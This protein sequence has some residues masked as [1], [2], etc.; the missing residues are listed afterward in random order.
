MNGDGSIETNG[1]DRVTQTVQDVFADP[2]NGNVQRTRTFVWYT[3]S[4]GYS[5]PVS[6]Q[7]TSTDGLKSWNTVYRDAGTPVTSQSQT[8]YAGNGNRYQRDIAPDSSYS[9]SA[10][11]NGRLISTTLNDSNNKQIG[12]TSY[13]YDA[14]GRQN[15]STDARNGTTTTTFVHLVTRRP[16]ATNN[17][18]L[19]STITTPMGEVT[20]Y[21]Y[22][23]SERLS[24]TGLPDGTSST[25]MLLPTGQTSLTY[26]S[27]VYPTGTGFD[28]QNR[29]TWLTNWN[30]FNNGRV[31]GVTTWSN[32][33]YRGWLNS[34]VY[35]DGTGPSYSYT[36]AGRLYNR[37]WARG[38]NTAYRYNVAGD[39]QTVAYNAAGTSNLLE[40]Y[41]RQGRISAILQGYPYN[42]TTRSYNNANQVL[43]ESYTLGGPLQNYAVSNAYDGNLRRTTTL[44]LSNGTPICAIYY[45][46]DNA[47]RLQSISDGINSA[48]YSYLANSSLVS[49]I[50]FAS[51]STTAVTTWKNYDFLNRLTAITSVP[52]ASGQWHPSYQYRYNAANQRTRATL[53]DNSYWLYGYD[54][55][56]QVTNANKYW[57]NGTPVPG[58]QFG[59]AFDNIGNRTGTT[60][61]GNQS[62][63]G[64][65]SATYTAND[66][67]QYTS[68]TVPNGFDILGQANVASAVL[69]NGSPVGYRNGEFYQSLFKVT[70]S[71]APVWVAVTNTAT[72]SSGGY[73]NVIG[74]YFIPQTN[75]NFLSDLDGNLTNDG[76]FSYTWDAE[77]RLIA[78]SNIASIPSSPSTSVI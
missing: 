55:L 19:P 40:T 15:T 28:K 74:N 62:G 66:L 5:S 3:N 56:G 65:R 21:Y 67:N 8:V 75:E 29:M 76:R 71:S 50:V 46:Y 24:G 31:A 41:D 45:G 68:R 26:G 60:M 10:Y 63:G 44:V 43:E 48:T 51:N 78:V 70:N 49:N 1:T 22:D 4:N 18:D 36:G 58:E 14:H 53:Y 73:S 61:G 34:K 35:A 69:V 11:L 47:S 64:L 27:R 72:N 16:S 77:N 25:N 23:T 9:V 20:T 39:L 2:V 30:S 13:G 33:Q 57:Q 32:D 38:T 12:Q 6:L 7:E 52:G 37:L 17:A 59:D 42:A 54:S